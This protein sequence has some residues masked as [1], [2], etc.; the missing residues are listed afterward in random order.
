MFKRAQDLKGKPPAPKVKK[1]ARSAKTPA[2]K[3][4]SIATSEPI[5]IGDMMELERAKQQ[6]SQVS[7]EQSSSMLEMKN[8]IEHLTQR[9]EQ[10]TAARN[11]MEVKMEDVFKEVRAMA[12]QKDSEFKRSSSMLDGTNLNAVMVEIFADGTA[13]ESYGNEK[14]RALREAIMNATLRVVRRKMLTA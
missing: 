11:A 4:K 13:P 8:I 14:N 10:E 12:G 2:V 6:W 7:V 5:G 1:A 3:P 9:L